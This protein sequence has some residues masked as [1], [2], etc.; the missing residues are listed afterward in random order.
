MKEL[1]L[2]LVYRLYKANIGDVIENKYVRLEGGWRTDDDRYVNDKGI[3]TRNLI[4]KF[5]FKDHTDGL[6][7][8]ASNAASNAYVPEYP[9]QDWY[10]E[11]FT[12]TIDP[13]LVYEARY[14]TK[15]V[16]IP[17]AIETGPK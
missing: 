14:E 12:D 5:F 3:F 9:S 8:C 2:E 10:Y 1:P 15:A 7:Y 11:P 17:M 4:Y 6:Y 16:T 13:F